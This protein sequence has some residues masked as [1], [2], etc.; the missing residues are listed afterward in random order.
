MPTLIIWRWSALVFAFGLTAPVARAEWITPDSIPNPPSAISS[1]NGTPVS[2]GNA[3]IGQYSGF[4]LVFPWESAIT[5]LNGVSVWAPVANP[6]VTTGQSSS[7][8]INYSY[9][10]SVLGRIVAPISLNPRT[11]SS[12][13]VEVLGNPSAQVNAYS[14]GPNGRLLHITPVIESIAGGQD[15]TF[16]GPG[17][18]SF[19]VTQLTGSSQPY[20]VAAVSLNPAP[21]PEPLPE[22]SGL[23]LA[24]L[25]ALGLATGA[26]RR[27]FRKM[28]WSAQE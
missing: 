5:K 26:G 14:Y 10:G 12:L 19:F 1:A 9:G 27:S 24:G 3:V 18:G 22:P 2:A 17:I 23:V 28:A 16:T 6:G 15:W 8:S 11:V 4:G 25:G 13:T 20:G 7:G 21:T